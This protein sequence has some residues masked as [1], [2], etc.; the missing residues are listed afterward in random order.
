MHNSDRHTYKLRKSLH[1]FRNL[2]SETYSIWKG[3]MKDF[4]ITSIKETL[5]Q[6]HSLKI[7]ELSDTIKDLNISS[8]TRRHKNIFIELEYKT[9]S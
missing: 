5:I 1:W 6:K 3:R 2:Q 9:S 7:I 8:A 4:G